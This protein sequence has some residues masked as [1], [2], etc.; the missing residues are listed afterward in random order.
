[1]S[2]FNLNPF[3]AFTGGFPTG[4]V[5]RILLKKYWY[6]PVH[7]NG[8]GTTKYAP[9]GMRK[10]EALLIKEFGAHN[11]AIVHPDN[12]KKVVGPKTKVIGISSMEPAGTGFVSRTYTSFMGFGGEPVAAA[13]F[14]DLIRKPILRKWGAKIVLG[15]SG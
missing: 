2:D 7:N 11:V 14:R 15:G 9:Y 13:E 5:P 4:I 6:P 10:I 8:D 1:M 3:R 12:L